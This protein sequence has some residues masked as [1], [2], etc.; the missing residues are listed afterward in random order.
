MTKSA[1]EGPATGRKQVVERRKFEEAKIS[2][3]AVGI[4]KRSSAVKV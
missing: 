1:A 2:Y 4:G 3:S